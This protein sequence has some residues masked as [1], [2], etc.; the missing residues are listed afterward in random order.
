[1]SSI[2]SGARQQHLARQ[3]LDI[4]ASQ[5][6][7][8]KRTVVMA[9]MIRLAG[10]VTELPTALFEDFMALAAGLPADAMPEQVA[11]PAVEQLPETF[12]ELA[13]GVQEWLEEFPE[14]LLEQCLRLDAVRVFWP[15][16]TRRERLFYGARGA[17]WPTSHHWLV[18][19][20]IPK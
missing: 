1:M 2:S 10:A 5:G 18:S 3:A 14:T 6:G 11:P 19:S 7:I 13:D 9:Q 4:L 20:A 12:D 17:V 8:L 15:A 16:A